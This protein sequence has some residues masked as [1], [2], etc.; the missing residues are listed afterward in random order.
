MAP[1]YL[2]TT[3]LVEVC[4]KGGE[5]ACR[6]REFLGRHDAVQISAYA[7]KEF[8]AGVLHSLVRFFN[9]LDDG[10]DQEVARIFSTIGRMGQGG[11]KRYPQQIAL[12][13]AERL[14]RG[15]AHL[16]FARFCDELS[17]LILDAWDEAH[18][19]GELIAPIDCFDDE[20]PAYDDVTGRFV[21]P[22]SWG[23]PPPA[24]CCVARLASE[25]DVV[26]GVLLALEAESGQKR[27]TR[28]RIDALRAAARDPGDV[29]RHQC[30]HFGDFAV[31]LF[32]PAEAEILSTNTS[33]FPGLCQRMGKKFCD[34]LAAARE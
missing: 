28:K 23:N 25:R 13:V 19:L 33:D 27:E 21:M 34:P 29:D 16:E 32:A 10:G 6:I 7:L 5:R 26:T 24:G 8:R 14:A 9:E 31:I 30:R 1:A 18:A 4:V 17:D 15:S 11:Y 3:I 20:G 22:V 2:D 12:Q